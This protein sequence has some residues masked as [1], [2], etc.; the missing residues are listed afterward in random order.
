M[1][2]KAQNYGDKQI[3]VGTIVQV[4]FADVDTTRAD[5]KNLTLI[6]VDKVYQKGSGLTMYRLASKAGVLSRLY[7]PSYITTIAVDPKILGLQSVLDKWKGLP[8]MTECKTARA[9]SLVGVQGKHLGCKCKR[10]TCR[11]KRCSCFQNG[12]KCNSSCH[13]VAGNKLCAYLQGCVLL[14][15]KNQ[16]CDICLWRDLYQIKIHR[17][18][19]HKVSFLDVLYQ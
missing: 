9:V 19:R 13:R 14:C 5:G 10:G 7:H 18:S 3:D 6:V 12:M 16:R 1:K 11:T 15:S 8:Q 4:P 17:N 2:I